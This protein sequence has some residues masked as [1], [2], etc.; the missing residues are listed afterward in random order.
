MN[1]AITIAILLASCTRP[2]QDTGTDAGVD[3]VQAP[4]DAAK[5]KQSG[6]NMG[7]LPGARTVTLTPDDPIPAELLNELQDVPRFG[8]K[9]SN[10]NRWLPNIWL[11]NGGGAVAPT[12]VSNPQGG[13]PGFPVWRLLSDTFFPSPYDT[14]IPFS[15][16]DRIK[17]LSFDIYGDAAVDITGVTLHY[18]SQ[19]DAAGSHA[20]LLGVLAVAMSNVAATWATL[21]VTIDAGAADAVLL[22]STGL[23]RLEVVLDFGAV[24]SLYVGHV[25][26][27]FD[28]PMP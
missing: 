25:T 12:C 24:H 23:L 2:W 17:A 13:Q 28:R 14:M 21:T 26:A 27:S 5:T 10:P 3:A 8:A 4:P 11:P 6:C 7:L 1:R 20:T 16:G 18:Y 19:S 15:P 22:A 9:A